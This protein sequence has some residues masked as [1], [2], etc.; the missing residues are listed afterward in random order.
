MT[1][2]FK[3][4]QMCGVLENID[5]PD[6]SILADGIFNRNLAVKGDLSLGKQVSSTDPSG[7]VTYTNTGGNINYSINGVDYAI[8]PTELSQLNSNLATQTFVSDAIAAIPPPDLTGYA[9]ET[10]VNTAIS[11]IPP[12][13]LTG[14]ATE[15]FVSDAI[16]AIPP[17]DFTGYATE[18]FVTNAIDAITGTDLSA[19]ATISYVDTA[20]A[21]IPP[22]DL[23]GYATEN[24]VDTLVT[25]SIGGIDFS[26]LAPKA[27]PALTGVPT[28]PTALSSDSSTQI[29]TTAFVKNQDYATNTYVDSAVSGIGISGYVKLTT[30]QTINGVK[31]F[32]SSPRVPDLTFIESEPSEVP[33]KSYVDSRVSTKASLSQIQSNDNSWTGT[34]AFNT[35]LPTSTLTPSTATQLTTKSYVDSVIT[36]LTIGSYALDA[37]AVHLTGNETIDGIKTFNSSPIVPDVSSSDTNTG[38]AINKKYCDDRIA[39]LV[40]SSPATLDTLNELATALGNDPNFATTMTTNLGLKAPLA[41]PSFTGIP[42]APTASQGDNSSQLATTA[43]VDTGLATKTTL[44]AVQSNNN[45][46]TG[47]NAFNTSLPTST[48]TPIT[49][50]QLTT[51]DYVDTQVATKATLADIQGNNNT[52]TG[53]NAFN[54]SLPTSTLNPS[55]STQLTTK[56]YVDGQVSSKTTLSEIQGNNNTWTGTNAFNSY[57]PT[58]SLTPTTSTQLVTK[59]YVDTENA[60]YGRLAGTN[61]WTGTSNTFVNEIDCRT[62]DTNAPTSNNNIFSST[63]SGNTFVLHND[64]H[65]GNLTIANKGSG[66]IT[67]R[68]NG[69]GTINIATN[70]TSSTTTTN[71]GRADGGNIVNIGAFTFTGNNLKLPSSFT[72]P[73]AGQIGYSVVATASAVTLTSSTFVSGGITSL[74]LSAGVWLLN[75]YVHYYKG[76]NTSSTTTMLF[77][78]I[79]GISSSAT[80]NNG[81]WYVR[82][83][84]GTSISTGF[85]YPTGNAQRQVNQLTRTVTLT[86]ANTLYVTCRAIFNLAAG[87]TLVAD[88]SFNATRIA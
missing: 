53:T 78:T 4:S 79:N 74:S 26:T 49:A 67:I 55:S 71:I 15:T 41:S 54:T 10:Y 34:N 48:L 21:A 44:S 47:T 62:I 14:Y 19:Y 5:Y 28:A 37:S 24:Y 31:T 73:T 38:K 88:C 27:S 50:T 80:G 43:Y 84:Y 64:S 20:I 81:G 60:L 6:G 77:E 66:A 39:A 51:K 65:S 36:G 9:T 8:T 58:S 13:D 63:T 18:T 86:G 75:A 57:L 45:T 76:A 35:S 59:N 56:S 83:N 33:N 42:T 7:V 11:D 70:T 68:D 1:N 12:P 69:S 29:A 40:A 46:W 85:S 30:N 52:W 23:T 72:T 3:S 22:T 25:T 61:T 16:A 2:R 87:D 32:T 82:N 17:P